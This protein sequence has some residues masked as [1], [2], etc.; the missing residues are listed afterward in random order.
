MSGSW[1]I[2]IIVMRP[3]RPLQ[4]TKPRSI[5]SALN[6]HACGFAAERQVVSQPHVLRVQS[7]RGDRILSHRAPASWMQK[8]FVRTGGWREHVGV[9]VSA[10]SSNESIEDR[11]IERVFAALDVLRDTAPRQLERIPIFTLG[12]TI[13][14]LDGA[15][16]QWRSDLGVCLLSERFVIAQETTP[17]ELAST[18]V[19]EVT[20]ARLEH[21]GFRSAN[22]TR[23]R[24]ERIC[25]LAQRNF[26]LSLPPSDE[27]SR[28]EE[29]VAEYLAM[30]PEFWSDEQLAVRL[31]DRVALWP[32]WHRALWNIGWI[33]RVI[34]RRAG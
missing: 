25:F 6:H 23:A 7:P 8:A 26:V 20:H 11:A 22:A 31:R 4:Q 12:L 28:L 5:L 3:N 24:I 27:R 10:T 30:D 18:I 16:G 9:R 13:T 15:L 17:S 1:G 21:A 33:A 34:R 19:H 32:F 2:E 29:I 14:P